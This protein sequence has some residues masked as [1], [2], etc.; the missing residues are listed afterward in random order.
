MAGQISKQY[1]KTSSA[2]ISGILNLIGVEVSDTDY[3]NLEGKYVNEYLEELINVGEDY[4]VYLTLNGTQK[5]NYHIALDKVKYFTGNIDPR[6]ITVVPVLGLSTDE[7]FRKEYDK[8]SV[9]NTINLRLTNVVSGDEVE[10]GGEYMQVGQPISLAGDDYLIIFNTTNTNYVIAL[11]DDA[12]YSGSILRRELS[13]SIDSVLDKVYNGNPDLDIANITLERIISSD[14]VSLISAMYE[15]YAIG[16]HNII[17]TLGGVDKDNYYVKA[18]QGE[19]LQQR[20]TIRLNYGDEAGVYEFVFVND[21]KDISYNISELTVI[22]G[23]SLNDIQNGSLS[24]PIATRDGYRHTGWYV[25]SALTVAFY[26]STV[27]GLPQFDLDTLN[28]NGGVLNLY[29][30]WVINSYVLNLEVQ[31]EEAGQMYEVST[32]GG[33]YELDGDVYNISRTSINCVY[34]QQINFGFIPSTHY[35]FNGIYNGFNLL[36]DELNYTLN[37]V[38]GAMNLVIKFAKEIYTVEIELNADIAVE[39]ISGIPYDWQVVGNKLQKAVRFS[40]SL[41]LP[42]ISRMGYGFSGYAITFGGAVVYNEELGLEI[43]ADAPD[44]KYYA[45]W[46]A[47]EY[48]LYLDYAGGAETEAYDRD[49]TDETGW[50]IRVVF[51]GTI[52]ALPQLLR[53]GYQQNDWLL[54][55]NNNITDINYTAE[56]V[57]KFEGS[58]LFTLTAVWIRG[59]NLIEVSSNLDISA[60]SENNIA[61]YKIYSNAISINYYIN[62]INLG[63]YSAPFNALTEDTVMFDASIL[64]DFYMFDGWYV[65]SVKLA[66][67]LQ[68][69]NDVTYENYGQILV[70]SNFVWGNG[71]PD[72]EAVYAPFEVEVQIADFD[73]LRG[74]AELNSGFFIREDQVLTLTGAE[75]YAGYTINAGYELTSVEALN[76]TIIETVAGTIEITDFSQNLLL[77]FNFE[78]QEYTLTINIT[79]ATVGAES[80]E[81]NINSGEYTS[82]EIPV[83]IETEDTILIR[84]SVGYGYEILNWLVDNGGPNAILS[85]ETITYYGFS[86]ITEQTLSGFTLAVTVSIELAPIIYD[87]STDCAILSGGEY[88]TDA[89]QNQSY[90]VNDAEEDIVSAEYLSN[91]TFI[92]ECYAETFDFNGQSVTAQKY[93]FVGWYVNYSGVYAIMSTEEIYTFAITENITLTAVF[94]LKTFSIS[95]ELTDSEQGSITATATGEYFTNPQTVVYGENLLLSV[96]T[97][98]SKGYVFDHWNVVYIFENTSIETTF[99]SDIIETSDITNVRCNIVLEASFITR[100]VVITAEAIFIDETENPEQKIYITNGDFTGLEVIFNG[101]TRQECT[102]KAEAILPGYSFVGWLVTGEYEVT[103]TP[104]LIYSEGNDY[105][106]GGIIKIK[107]IGDDDNYLITARFERHSNQ[108][109]TSLKLDD[110]SIAGGGIVTSENGNHS[111]AVLTSY[112]KTEDPLIIFVYIYHGYHLDESTVWKEEGSIYSYFIAHENVVLTAELSSI[113]SLCIRLTIT[114]V[115]SNINITIKAERNETLI[116]FY[117]QSETGWTISAVTATIKY[118]TRDLIIEDASYLTPTMETHIFLGWSSNEMTYDFYILANGEIKFDEWRIPEDSINLYARWELKRVRLNV[119]IDPSTAVLLTNYYVELFDNLNATFQPIVENNNYYF[120]I[121][122]QFGISLPRVGSKFRFKEYQVLRP[123]ATGGFDWQVIPRVQGI[124]EYSTDLF[125]INSYNDY[126][127]S[128]ANDSGID[129]SE[130]SD[131]TMYVRLLFGINVNILDKNYYTSNITNETGGESLINGVIEN[132]IYEIGETITITAIPRDG[133]LLKY[134]LIDQVE[135]YDLTMEVIVHENLTIEAVYIGKPV[136]ITFGTSEYGSANAITG[137]N[138]ET[139]NEIVYYHVGDIINI[140]AT[141]NQGYTFKDYWSHNVTGVFV[142]IRYILTSADGNNGSAELTPQFSEKLVNIQFEIE[143][144]KGI[145]SSDEIHFNTS[146]AGTKITYSFESS[147]FSQVSIR[148]ITNDKYRFESIILVQG[149]TETDLTHLLVDGIFTFDCN[150]YG[151]VDNLLFKVNY[152]KIYWYDYVIERGLVQIDGDQVSIVRD[153]I[154]TGREGDPYRIGSID[155]YALWAYIINNQI[156]QVNSGKMPYNSAQTYYVINTEVNFS[157]R[158]WTPIGTIDNPFNGIVWIYENRIGIGI[159]ADDENYPVEDVFDSDVLDEWGGLFGALSDTAEITILQRDY[160]FM[161]IIGAISV[162][163][164]IGLICGIRIIRNRH[165]TLISTLDHNHFLD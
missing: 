26:A 114:E 84:I 2:T 123:N 101:E 42:N 51:D 12:D 108:V 1:D 66:D 5:D 115:V 83:L 149:S 107:L 131:G 22:Y 127:Y 129:L 59:E 58:D 105:V 85:N 109:T 53:A 163:F 52:G 77:T 54:K 134:W 43:T 31:T 153:L 36:S 156:Q 136:T 17:F 37:A 121:G 67:G 96:K 24:L 65:N 35:T 128:S 130:F 159:D 4:F 87:V 160:W 117:E 126:M 132:R 106:K 165:K 113:F 30:K 64:T 147:Y 18:Y 124:T 162:I 142:N 120:N 50:F 118:G 110:A 39:E 47:N 102:I 148:I 138:P 28:E 71:C 75:I 72:I 46:D 86:T 112:S 60:Y 150:A 38:T 61:D 27:V 104:F 8:T 137:G 15:S 74:T 21:G 161:I 62:N 92:P 146:T 164:I 144:S 140:S 143:G 99:G 57:W 100:D 45:N 125:V 13:V 20:I 19:I 154:G 48:K 14:D 122:A 23:T 44:L 79:G 91:V 34:Y 94:K 103:A 119:E 56:T 152:I 89:T 145:V 3:I 80:V 76:A 116:Q 68:V 32:V 40:E 29:A 141:A 9:V 158:Y 25:S 49:E 10:F 135:Y 41:S 7:A 111:G 157:A 95:F 98:A 93:E 133:Y 55:V 33:S 16:V 151:Y 63:L 70:I 139:I 97:S 155:D 88:I 69:I 73:N 81:Y 78:K 11:I 82:Y 6:Q 90:V